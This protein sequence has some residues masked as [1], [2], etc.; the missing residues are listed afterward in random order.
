MHRIDRQPRVLEQGVQQSV[1]A[2]LHGQRDRPARAG[3]A[4]FFQ[5]GVQ[6]LGRRLDHS[7]LNA[8][9]AGLLTGERMRLVSP[10]Q[11][12]EGRVVGGVHVLFFGFG[13]TG[14]RSYRM[15]RRR[16]R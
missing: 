9:R 8:V 1:A 13:G 10:V 5:P 4:Q 2:G 3:L 15:R 7:L 11:G 6:R 16:R 14:C 12:H